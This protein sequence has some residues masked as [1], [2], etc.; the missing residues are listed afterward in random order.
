MRNV[1]KMLFVSIVAVVAVS[2]VACNGTPILYG[3]EEVRSSLS[4][5]MSPATDGVAALTAGNRDFGFDLYHQ[6]VAANDG[7]NVF[8]SGH[9]VSIALAMAY[10]GAKGDT[11]AQMKTMLGFT[12]D[13]AATHVAFNALDLDLDKRGTEELAPDE[14][15]DPFELSVVNQAWGRVG[16]EF[17]ETYL[18]L[19]AL[20]YGAGMR[21]LDFVGD[22]DGSR[23]TINEW[24]EDETHERIVDLLPEGSISAATALVL[25]NVIYFK[26]SWLK[27]F[28]KGDTVDDEFT[29]LDDTTVAV[30]MMSKY[31]EARHGVGDG[32]EYLEVPYVGEKVAMALILPD[33]GRFDEVEAALDG[34]AFGGMIEDAVASTGTLRLPRFTFGFD[35]ALNDS[36]K[37]LGMTNAF[38]AGSADF[39]G[40]DGAPGNLFISLVQHKSFVAVDEDGTEAA[41]AT[42]VVMDE[43]SGPADTYD[44]T[45]DRPFLFAIIDR[46][47]GA[48][49]FLGRVLDPTVE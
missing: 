3:G 22:P 43:T 42:A 32:Y 25:T 24:V 31:D 18:D 23:V 48:V 6:L 16:F 14:G 30:K 2:A 4:R 44:L 29:R 5:E 13:D 7:K 46:P 19:L 26:A 10:A 34:P 21:L 28:D 40:I 37:A 9:S 12:G 8:I 17:L 27:K 20:N 15:G 1:F 11:A 47:T 35:S 45:F 49:L 33:A 41:A 36:L 38:G 39:S